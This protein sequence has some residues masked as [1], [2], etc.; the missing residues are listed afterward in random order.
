VIHV[1]A[2][3]LRDMTGRLLDLA[4]KAPLPAPLTTTAADARSTY[5]SRDF[6]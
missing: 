3:R 6:H 1:I 4:G 5:P 2:R